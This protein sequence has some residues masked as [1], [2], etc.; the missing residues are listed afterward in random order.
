MREGSGGKAV[1]AGGGVMAALAGAGK[2]AD[3][4]CRACGTAA[5]HT[6]EIAVVSHLDD[7]G[8][9]GV[10]GGGESLSHVDDLARLRGTAADELA[11]AQLN[12]VVVGE[13]VV[14]GERAVEHVATAT[15]RELGF[16]SS[17]ARKADR[18]RGTAPGPRPDRFPAGTRGHFIA[19]PES[20]PSVA[21]SFAD[22]FARGVLD[23]AMDPGTV[24]DL[25]D[26][27]LDVQSLAEDADDGETSDDEADK[28]AAEMTKEIEAHL[29]T[30]SPQ[31]RLAVERQ[32]GPPD[33]IA[34]RIAEA[35]PLR[36]G[37]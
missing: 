16:T 29:A 12:G 21:S 14:G 5:R 37:D 33:V 19:R 24:S 3:D 18:F 23:A 22:D 8:R 9:V 26:M 36:A 7:V 20:A 11:H 13:G 35:R 4:G 30:L 17:V 15:P 28:T 2:Y 25:V 32:L 6:D 31:A 1:A 27:L 34:Y 10:R